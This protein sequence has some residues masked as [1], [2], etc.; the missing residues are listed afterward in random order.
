MRSLSG[1]VF[2]LAL[3][4]GATA[5]AATLPQILERFDFAGTWAAQCERPAAPDNIIRRV[6]ANGSGEV[7]FVERF[8]EGYEPNRYTVVGARQG[9]HGLLN[10]NV[11]LDGIRQALTIKRSHGRLRTM[12]NRRADG[13]LLVQNGVVVTTG[14]P[15]PWLSRCDDKT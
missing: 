13:T 5:S 8:G 14:Q 3:L 12:R 15:T 9:K 4:F 1:I 10:V 2:T 11:E 7:S 6:E